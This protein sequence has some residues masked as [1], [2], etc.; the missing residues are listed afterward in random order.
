[1]Q[2]GQAEADSLLI[3]HL[4]EGGE[5]VCGPSITENVL[6]FECDI[7]DKQLPC[8][9]EVK[10]LK[11]AHKSKRRR[12]CPKCNKIFKTAGHLLRHITFHDQKQ[13]ACK[14]CAQ[15]FWTES[16]LLIHQRSHWKKQP[17]TSMTHGN[18]HYKSS[19]SSVP[20]QLHNKDCLFKCKQCN[21]RFTS[22]STL[23]V[24]NFY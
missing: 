14:S 22:V 17:R 15:T 20:E 7:S 12:P 19:S 8:I 13:H 10:K 21:K 24:S 1:M 23:Q 3:D 2:P 16:A 6:A 4:K 18:K 9:Q 5:T 11:L